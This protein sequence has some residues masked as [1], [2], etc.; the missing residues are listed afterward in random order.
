VS[1]C[2]W[3][4]EQAV[5]VALNLHI[6]RGVLADEVGERTGRR[7]DPRVGLPRRPCERFQISVRSPCR[8]SSRAGAAGASASPWPPGGGRA[9]LA[10]SRQV[11]LGRPLAARLLARPVTL[12]SAPQAKSPTFLPARSEAR[13]GSAASGSPALAD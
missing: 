1:G 6:A 10:R 3:G 13:S 5:I 12:S 2:G 4:V 9:V 11:V 8:P 7:E